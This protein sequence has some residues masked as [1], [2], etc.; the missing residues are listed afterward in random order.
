MIRLFVYRIGLTGVNKTSKKMSKSRGV[1]GRY[2]KSPERGGGGGR[3][4]D[5]QRSLTAGTVP[6][7][8]GATEVSNWREKIY[9]Y[10]VLTKSDEYEEKERER[11]RQSENGRP[12][13]NLKCEKKPQTCKKKKRTHAHT[14]KYCSRYTQCYRFSCREKKRKGSRGGRDTVSKQNTGGR[15]MLLLYYCCTEGMPVTQY[16][17]CCRRWRSIILGRSVIAKLLASSFD[18]TSIYPCCFC[19]SH[20]PTVQF[21]VFC[22]LSFHPSRRP[23]YFFLFKSPHHF[24]CIQV[25]LTPPS[26]SLYEVPHVYLFIALTTLPV[27][28]FATLFTPPLLYFC[29]FT[30]HPP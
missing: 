5:R 25:T 13:I 20:R 8:R 6:V 1:E 14:H 26:L 21:P 29:V 18:A 12:G 10:F 22:W 2:R 11:D 23:T 28:V 15:I 16:A 19:I 30:Q 4:R 9:L 3:D 24:F 17:H 27:L 7:K